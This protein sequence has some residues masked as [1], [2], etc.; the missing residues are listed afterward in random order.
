MVTW[1]EDLVGTVA[2]T[3]KVCGTVMV[4]HSY[5]WPLTVCPKCFP[6]EVRR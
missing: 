3:C 2:S 1:I 4:A 5:G 6:D